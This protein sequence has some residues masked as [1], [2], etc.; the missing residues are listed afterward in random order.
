MGLYGGQTKHFHIPF[1]NS[2][3]VLSSRAEQERMQ[4]V[5]TQLYGAI[6]AQSGGHGV[7]QKGSFSFSGT[8]V[9]LS[10]LDCYINQVYGYARD[11]LIWNGVV[12]GTNYLFVS[13]TAD[14]KETGALTTVLNTSGVVPS[15]SLLVGAA[16]NP[17]TGVTSVDSEPSG[18]VKNPSWQDHINDNTNPH[19]SILY[20]DE[21]VISGLEV[22]DTLEAVNMEV[23]NLEV[24]QQLV[25]SGIVAQSFNATDAY[26]DNLYALTLTGDVALFSGTTMLGELT[27]MSGA[28]IG[29]GLLTGDLA[30]SSGVKIDGVDVDIF[31]S[32]VEDHYTDYGN[33]HQVTADQIG[34]VS[35]SGSTMVGNL[36]MAS[37]VAVDGVDVSLLKRMI[38]GSDGTYVAPTPPWDPGVPGHLHN[39]SGLADR[40]LMYAPEYAD[41]VLY[42]TGSG[43]MLTTY[44]VDIYT[45]GHNAYEWLPA[46]NNESFMVVQRLGVPADF[47]TLQKIRY[48]ERYKTTGLP[49]TGADIDFVLLDT[50]GT[51]LIDTRSDSH[52]PGSSWAER[53]FTMQ[54]GL[55]I[56]GEF[57]T[58]KWIMSA[59]SGES[60]CLGE[61]VYEYGTVFSGS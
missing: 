52:V 9:W 33:P 30:V 31:W 55:G 1:P 29:G 26:I 45:S 28:T 38:D 54:S 36:D 34:A 8:S 20:Q 40:Y 57:A 25:A 60:V 59:L 42:G 39:Y 35:V 22:L 6:R 23:Q 58:A 47:R 4:I 11:T 24:I 56:P 51:I 53:E 43:I 37:G 12:S 15:D 18:Y 32:G 3:D 27:V 13:L 14:T 44:S 48:W 50:A 49:F 21:M 5:D 16:I 7:I 41:A 10:S 46:D 61:V 2:G 19:G 17:G